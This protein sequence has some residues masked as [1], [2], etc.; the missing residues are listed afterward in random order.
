MWQGIIQFVRSCEE[1]ILT[2]ALFTYKANKYW[3]YKYKD[4]DFQ[5]SLPDSKRTFW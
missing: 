3:Q 2:V 1:D 4:T 5:C